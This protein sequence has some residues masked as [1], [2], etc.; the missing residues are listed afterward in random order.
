VRRRDFIKV[1]AGSA[2]AWPLAARAEQSAMPVVG[3]L[4]AP[5]AAPY[6]RYVAAVHQGLK[7]VGYVE[8]Q[9][10]AMEYRWADN[11][12][13]RLPALAAD[14][15][16]RRVAVIIPIGG[17][18]A[19]VAAKAA[20]STIPIVFNL[21]ADPVGLNLV[22]NLSRPGGNITGIAMMTVEMETKRLELLHELVPASSSLAILLNPSSPQ[23]RPRKE[24]RNRRHAS[25]AGKF[26]F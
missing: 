18:P 11:Q 1:V 16:S 7:E 6:A 19:T 20:T 13:D 21:G 26:L 4:G 25:S 8:H 10:V 5:S 14:L 9:N 3:F 22:T 23:R 12:Y 15:V 24:K 17:A 2:A